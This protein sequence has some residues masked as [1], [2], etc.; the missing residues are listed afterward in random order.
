MQ[1]KDVLFKQEA[2]DQNFNHIEIKS[3]EN[4]KQTASPPARHRAP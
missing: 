1:I 2:F 3:Q 4:Y